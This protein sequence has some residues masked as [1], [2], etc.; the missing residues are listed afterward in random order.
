MRDVQVSIEDYY[1]LTSG[2][3]RSPEQFTTAVRSTVAFIQ[4]VNDVLRSDFGQAQ[5]YSEIFKRKIAS[6]DHGAEIIEGFRYVRNV[7]Q[8]LIHPVAPASAS[9]VGGMGL[10]YRTSAVWTP[11]PQR[12]HRQLHPRTRA[13]MPY[14]HALLEGHSVIDTFLDAARFFW[15]VC[16]LIVHRQN[17]GEWTGFPLRHQA[18]V[19]SRLHPEEPRWTPDDAR[20]TKAAMHW[21]SRRRPGGDLRVICGQLTQDG[22]PWI[23]GLTF[24]HQATYTAFFESPDQVSRDIELGYPYHQASPAHRLEVQKASLDYGGTFP[25]FLCSRSPL[26]D[27]VGAPISRLTIQ[28]DFFTYGS[29]EDFWQPML[30]ACL[31]DPIDRRKQ[32]LAA[33]FPIH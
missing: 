23:A 32:R 9:V 20:S 16:P 1:R 15:E 30:F 22:K 18:G 3:V 26:D 33:W 11:V 28:D 2:F 8:H 14:Y 6:S 19:S 27:W 31:T 12:V 29:I 17:N 21:M 25:P 10:G 13:L 5:K 24:R 4:K 7:G